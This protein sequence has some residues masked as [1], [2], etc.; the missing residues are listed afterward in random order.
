M[1]DPR[2]RHA[3]R[4]FTLIEVMIALAV[5]ATALVALLGLHHQSLQSVIRSQDIARA[6][7]LAQRL[8]TDAELQR[9]PELGRT[10]GNFG[11]MYPG[12]YGNFRWERTVDPGGAFPDVRKVTV[13][14]FYGPRFGRRLEVVEFMHS[15]YSPQQQIR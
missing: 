5:V 15:P 7:L 9:F 12:Q 6:G 14:V 4:A 10:A 13:R 3:S 1:T 8:M 2:R 11:S